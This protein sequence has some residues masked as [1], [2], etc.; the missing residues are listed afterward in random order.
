MLY[1]FQYW[2][3]VIKR[4][5]KATLILL[6][7]DY[8]GTL[9]P[10]VSSPE[11]AMLPFRAREI[12]KQ[13]SQR[14]LFK[15]AII[16]G[17]SLSDIRTLVGLENIIYVGNHGLEMECPAC[18]C[19]RQS[20][21]AT[22]FIH[23]IAKEFQPELKKLEQRLREKLAGIDSVIIED[24]GLTLSIHYRLAKETAVQKIKNL[25]FEAIED[26]EARDKLQVTE[27]KK[28]LEVR[29][30]V[31]W[32]KGKTIEWLLEI[33]GMPGSLPVFA[34]DDVADEDGFKVLQRVGGISIFIGEDKTSSTANY[35]LDSPEQ[36]HHWL[37]KLL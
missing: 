2:D 15:L 7:L 1:L 24:K 28:V 13:I 12:L 21:E 11:M 5:K 9:T 8:D 27:G 4:V 35:Y 36:L 10:I 22:T 16:S 33:Y 34:G 3:E 26:R 23:P 32:N 29:P 25:F 6:F 37:E 17:R 31:D 30:S 19:Q 20:S 18:Y 14:N